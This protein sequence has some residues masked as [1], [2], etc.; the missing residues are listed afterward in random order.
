MLIIVARV[1]TSKL[2]IR[3]VMSRLFQSFVYS[4][5]GEKEHRGYQHD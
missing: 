2:K 3:K 1:S 5:I 4:I